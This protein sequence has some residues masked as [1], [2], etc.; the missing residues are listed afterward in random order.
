MH[1]LEEIQ[2]LP[3][4]VIAKHQHKQ[5]V[6]L[7]EH[8]NKHSTNFRARMSAAKLK[9]MDLSTREGL[10]K[11]P[12]LSRRELQTAKEEI[13]CTMLPLDHAPLKVHRSTGSTGEPVTVRRTAI[14]ALFYQATNLRE[15]LWNQRDFSGTYASIRSHVPEGATEMPNWGE[16]Y[17]WLFNTGPVYL[18]P[19]TTDIDQQVA[20]L[21][22]INPDYLLTYPS[23]LTA[24]LQDFE[25]RKLTL[26]RLR[27]IRSVGETLTDEL[28]E[29]ARRIFHVEIADTYSSAEVGTIALQCPESGLYHVMSEGLIVEVLDEQGHPCRPG[30]IGRVVVT[31][32][33]NFATPLIRYDLNDYAEVGEACPCGRGLKVLKRIVGRSQNMLLLPDGRRNWP[34]F[35]VFRFTEIAP[36]R[37]HQLIQRSREQIEV[38]LV[39]DVPLTSEQETRLID[40]IQNSLGYPFE[41]KLVYFDEKIPR[42]KGGKFEEFA[43]EIQ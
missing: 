16:P 23:N 33:H 38:R 4:D 3:A 42:G 9:P 13:F 26:P 27:Q 15:N 20:W 2:W 31:D 37:Q 6:T 12:V 32:L 10:R 40:L 34:R 11:L 36:I 39:A 19:I 30:R 35:W 1:Q 21:K 24:L 28:R 18:K 25:R 7:A 41:L 8:A 5:L 43:C 17:A 14:S 22:K 29:Y